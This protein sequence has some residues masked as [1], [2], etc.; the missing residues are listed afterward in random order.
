MSLRRSLALLFVAVVVASCAGGGD[1]SSTGRVRNVQADCFATEAARTTAVTQISDELAVASSGLDALGDPNS[2]TFAYNENAARF[3]KAQAA[4]ATKAEELDEAVENPNPDPK[5]IARL[6]GE[7]NLAAVERSQ[8][9][10]AFL[11]A[12]AKLAQLES[13][14]A[15]VAQATQEMARITAVPVCPSDV[16]SETTVAT[17]E[18]SASDS[19]DTTINA[20][21]ETTVAADLPTTTIDAATATTVAADLPTTTVS[22]DQATV[23]DA[24]STTV[25][26]TTVPSSSDYSCVN[27]PAQPP[28]SEV[29]VGE[30]FYIGLQGCD[31]ALAGRRE[32]VRLY[33][34]ES[35]DT[36]TNSLNG[37]AG[38]YFGCRVG[39]AGLKVFEIR[40]EELPSYEVLNFASFTVL[41]KEAGSVSDCK[42]LVPQAS[43]DP[44]TFTLS[45]TSNC[46]A[47]KKLVVSV[48]TAG[49][50][51]VMVA[52]FLRSSPIEANI[53][54]LVDAYPS[55]R[56]TVVHFCPNALPCGDL[57]E[58]GPLPTADEPASAGNSAT[59]PCLDPANTLYRCGW[60]DVDDDGSV[61]NI[62]VCSYEV[63]GSGSFGGR[64]VVL[65]TRQMYDG[66]VSGYFPAYYD[67]ARNRFYIDPLGAKGRDGRWFT[68]GDDWDAITASL[69]ASTPA[70]STTSTT[71]AAA[72]TTSTSS[73]SSTT[74]APASTT[75][76]TVAAAVTTSTSSTTLAPASTTS[77]TVA[78]AAT[79]PEVAST[80]PNIVITPMPVSALTR[81]DESGEANAGQGGSVDETP[82]PIPVSDRANI[83]VC[84]AQCM[85]DARES[86]EAGDDAT[87]EIELS[88]GV[89]VPAENQTI[90]VNP[91]G[92]PLRLRVTPKSGPAVI[93][94]GEVAAASVVLEQA[95]AGLVTASSDGTI[96][97]ATGNVVGVVQEVGSVETQQSGISTMLT[98]VLALVAAVIA[99]FVAF[100]KKFFLKRPTPDA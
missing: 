35:C 17:D 81:E 44:A 88:D 99:L 27:S 47:T 68:G 11:D 23:E 55:A 67:S 70:A 16:A 22:P 49:P 93:L 3:D 50:P 4:F 1:E 24:A 76:T 72:L 74:L 87:V 6:T 63:C 48:W 64:R 26:S 79:Q 89:W 37:I 59:N 34:D 40:V 21:T 29:V 97:D 94:G 14:K 57:L 96:T 82:L 83:M 61:V 15:R 38:L 2:L 33:H 41:A 100:L 66:N 54:N 78:A 32:D 90:P 65:Q 51:T 19:A 62:I 92:A 86:A 73:T 20:A 85:S 8:A 18:A 36:S 25:Q 71:V 75:S 69:L 9:N 60:A 98:I 31:I 77:T 46:A 95:S 45:A 7:L 84:D 53:R 10:F 12:K 80:E 13:A 43:Y 58:L 28:P 39:S 30:L 56:L 5:E 52:N 91:S 42:G